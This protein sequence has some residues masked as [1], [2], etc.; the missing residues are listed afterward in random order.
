MKRITSILINISLCIYLLV[1]Q[2]VPVQAGG[3]RNPA[4]WRRQKSTSPW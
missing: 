2:N 4:Q 3:S 1:G